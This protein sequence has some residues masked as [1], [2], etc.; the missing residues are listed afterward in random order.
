MVFLSL[1]GM[2]LS[3][4]MRFIGH[5]IELNLYD[6]AVVIPET[7]VGKNTWQYSVYYAVAFCYVHKCEL[8]YICPDHDI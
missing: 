3:C 8:S 6:L 2:I 1:V 5:T 7:I 4:V